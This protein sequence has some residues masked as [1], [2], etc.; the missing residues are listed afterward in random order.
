MNHPVSAAGC[1]VIFIRP[2][3]VQRRKQDARLLHRW[4]SEICRHIHIHIRGGILHLPWA[5]PSGVIAPLFTKQRAEIFRLR[6]GSAVESSLRKRPFSLKF[7]NR[8]T[9]LARG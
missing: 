7:F 1:E 9:F 2:L 6:P 8:Q 5:R 3:P 4:I